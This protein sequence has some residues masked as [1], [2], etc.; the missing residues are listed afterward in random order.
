MFSFIKNAFS[1]IKLGFATLF[2]AILAYMYV[3][4]EKKNKKIDDLENKIIGLVNRND[5][6]VQTNNTNRKN[7]LKTIH[8]KTK[9]AQTNKDI[10][11][12]IDNDKATEEA[13]LKFSEAMA[14][15]IAETKVADE[16]GNGV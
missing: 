16:G 8:N 9:V 6:L 12:H 10:Q 5:K 15:R 13:R 3:K 14:K 1:Y 4:N 7:V 2:L 11:V